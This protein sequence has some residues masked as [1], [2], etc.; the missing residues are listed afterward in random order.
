MSK[1]KDENLDKINTSLKF[2]DEIDK[3]D[4]NLINIEYYGK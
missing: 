2:Q 1:L 4:I 3:Q